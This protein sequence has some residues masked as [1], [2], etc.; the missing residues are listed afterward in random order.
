MFPLIND[1]A[2]KFNLRNVMGLIVLYTGFGI[3]LSVFMIHGFIAT[4][5]LSLEEVAKVEGLG[6]IKTFFK[7]VIPL[8]RQI[9]TTILILNTMW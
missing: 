2:V 5:P 3:S 8:L 7:V 1:V 9:L 4:I 6:P